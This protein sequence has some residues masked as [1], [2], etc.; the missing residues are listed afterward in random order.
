[1]LEAADD[2]AEIG[3]GEGLRDAVLVTTVV[4]SR[5]RRRT[6]LGAE[7]F[8]FGL[9]LGR[10]LAE[11]IRLGVELGELLLDGGGIEVLLDGV[12]HLR[13]NGE[14]KNSRVC[15]GNFFFLLLFFFQAVV[16]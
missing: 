1:L 12:S 2:D 5:C 7:V 11:G 10:F 13:V 15:L 3:N 9:Q 4:A 6:E 16:T 14:I 8:L